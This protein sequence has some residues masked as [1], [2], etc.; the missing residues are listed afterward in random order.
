VKSTIVIGEMNARQK[1]WS[2]L[3][4]RAI[5]LR[6]KLPYLV[7]YGDEIDVRVTFKEAKLQPIEASDP[8]VVL[9]AA[10][11]QLNT[12]ALAKVERGL[13]EIGI[14]FDKGAGCDGRDWE[15]DWSLSGPIS[16]TFRARAKKPERRQ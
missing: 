4:H 2:R 15:W 10:Q 5:R 12:G 9:A 16:V 3:K 14:G 11:R 6:R 8:E 1:F 7:W 13:S